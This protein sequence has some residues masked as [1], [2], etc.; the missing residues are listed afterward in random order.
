MLGDDALWTGSD[1]DS[2][3]PVAVPG[4][5]GIA[6]IDGRRGPVAIASGGRLACIAGDSLTRVLFCRGPVDLGGIADA[7]VIASG[8]SH[9]C[10]LRAARS[11]V[12]W[13]ANGVGQ[14]GDGTIAGSDTPVPVVG[15]ADAVAIGAGE[16]HT[17]ALLG[18]GDLYCWGDNRHGQLGDR[19]SVDSPIPVKVAGVT[20]GQIAPGTGLPPPT[21]S[22]AGPRPLRDRAPVVLVPGLDETTAEVRPPRDPGRPE[23]CAAA[24]AFVLLCQRLVD[25]RHPVY[26][27][28]A[29][30]RATGRALDNRGDLDENARRLRV[31]VAGISRPVIAGHSMGGLIARIAVSRYHVAARALVTIGTPH[32]GSPLADL[33]ELGR[34]GSCPASACDAI[35][36]AAR[37]IETEAGAVA[38]R[39]MTLT[40]R[41]ADR[42]TAPAMPVTVFA[43]TRIGR[44][45]GVATYMLPNDGAVGQSSAWGA[46][47]NLGVR[48]KVEA[49]L[50]H[51]PLLFPGDSY[52]EDNEFDDPLIASIIRQAANEQA[53][54]AVARASSAS[55]TSR[56]ATVALQLSAARPLPSGIAADVTKR[57]GVLAVEPFTVSCDGKS[58]PSIAL[59]AG[60]Y[61]LLPQQ[62]GCKR[63]TMPPLRGDRAVVSD[64]NHNLRARIRRTHNGYD[65]TIAG[66]AGVRV[67]RAWI[68][69]RGH[70]IRLR[71]EHGR[72]ETLISTRIAR[73]ADSLAVVAG[74]HR[75]TATWAS[76]L[77]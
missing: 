57:T 8:W 33:V 72:V 45:F 35:R 27:V 42:L 23:N 73:Q 48:T 69:R 49:P 56:R 38:I 76:G 10:V 70:R 58:I 31:F 74:P 54:V 11:I 32:D 24:G 7:T 60:L 12:C 59:G 30:T 37:G 1:D 36:A 64:A 41:L 29:A 34:L 16:Q 2:L 20:S 63:A 44:G 46:L 67:G 65:V 53:S 18:A 43:G 75:Y 71:I 21:T 62:M 13:G 14:L 19:A 77:R 15:I 9:T 40:A 55:Q 47:A 22:P 39:E 6:A 5:A 68:T 4:I 51:S 66:R 25:A 17:C 61:G 28:P 26:V 3:T 52:H 50:W